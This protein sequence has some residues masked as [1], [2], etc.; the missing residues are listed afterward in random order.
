MAIHLQVAKV[1]KIPSTP[2][3]IFLD[4][5]GGETK[6]RRRTI[7]ATHSAFKQKDAGR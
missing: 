2:T 5:G 6:F 7:D 4:G 3:I 1:I